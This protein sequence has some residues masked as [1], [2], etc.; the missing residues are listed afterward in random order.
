[1]E[2]SV[3]AVQ[4]GL[5]PQRL[6][7]LFRFRKL[8]LPQLKVERSEALSGNNIARF[9][10]YM[11]SYLIPIHPVQAQL[12]DPGSPCT[13]SY[14]QHRARRCALQMC[15][16]TAH[17]TPNL[18]TWFR[19][20]SYRGCVCYHVFIYLVFA[21]IITGQEFCVTQHLASCICLS[22]YWTVL[23]FI[24][25]LSYADTD[26]VEPHGSRYGDRCDCA[27]WWRQR[28]IPNYDRGNK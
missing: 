21:I 6:S 13:C 26:R 22:L 12:P 17:K 28:R 18:Q 7:D 11:H 8:L 2:E 25:C 10:L 1:M 23:T 9:T 15:T 27:P 16:W 20:K 14:R 19:I 3:S 4:K 5:Y 24:C